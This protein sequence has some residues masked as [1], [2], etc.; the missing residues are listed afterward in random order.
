SGGPRECPGKAAGSRHDVHRFRNRIDTNG[1]SAL[2]PTRTKTH[3]TSLLPTLRAHAA[4]GK[5]EPFI[6]CSCAGHY[7][8]GMEPAPRVTFIAAKCLVIVFVSLVLVANNANGQDPT[9][10]NA[11]NQST[12]QVENTVPLPTHTGWET[13]LKDTG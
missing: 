12:Q 7:D 13:L 1:T 2:E 6:D 11:S 8:A 3:Y 5:S 4:R 9:P 10:T